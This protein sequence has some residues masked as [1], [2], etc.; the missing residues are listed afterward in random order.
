MRL[1][2]NQQV[3]FALVKAGLWEQEARLLSFSEVDYEEVMRLAEEQSVIGLVT[4]GL[5][6]VQDIK[7]PQ[8]WLLQ[9]IGS[10]LQVEQKNKDMN[11]FIARLIEKL[12]KAD[13]YALL[14]KGQGIA[15]N[16]EKPFW[17]TSGDVDLYLSENNYRAAKNLLIPL[18]SEVE[19]E[20]EER[21]HL[22]LTIDQWVVELHGTMK[23]SLSSK[24]NKGLY[25][26]HTNTFYGR[27]VRSWNNDGTTVFLPSADNDVIII[28]T[29]I[30]QHFFVGGIG[31]RQICDW[32]RLLWTYSESLNYGLLE[33]RIQKMGLLSEWRAFGA[34]AV[35]Y[36][37]M[38]TEAMPFYVNTTI[39]KQKADRICAFI[40]E[41][42]SFGH[43]REL[44]QGVATSVFDRRKKLIINKVI[45]SFTLLPIFPLDSMRFLMSFIYDG[46]RGR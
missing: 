40:F 29:H 26:V 34:F 32:C 7:V 44:E 33:S 11:V 20:Y 37:G 9:F 17:R 38:P 45:D 2:K 12:R 3:F 39:W 22:G 24:I 6:H 13:I 30:L 36:L 28:F 31:L 21:L 25:A 42:G 5:E 41:T 1:D 16:Y 46:L 15:Q 27:E 8:E 10:T 43:K 35:E 14:V 4:A 18:A 19:K 23:T